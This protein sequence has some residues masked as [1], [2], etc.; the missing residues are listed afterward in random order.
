MTFLQPAGLW[1]LGLIPVILLIHLFRASPRRITVPATFLWH[2]LNKDLSASR[3]H[4]PPRPSWLLLLQ[5][6]AVGAVALALANPRVVAPPPRHLVLLID[7]SASMLASD[8]AP[9]RFDQAIQRGRALLA[10]LGPQDTVSVIRVG[11][12][13]ALVAESIDPGAA[14]ASLGG[15]RAGAGSAAMREA[16]AFG[17]AL[18]NRSP[19]AT[20]EIVVLSDGAFAEPGDL[21]A[22][23]APIRFEPVGQS[24]E[25][26]AVTSV[27]VARQPRP[28]AG[29]AVFAR[30]VNYANR[31][32]RLPVRLLADSVAVDTR[33]VDVA[34]RARAELTFSAPEGTRRLAVS[35]G[36][37]DALAADDL[38]EVS[39]DAGQARSALLVSRLPGVMERALR[40]IPDLRVETV[41]PEAY[42]SQAAEL[43]VLDGFLPERLPGGQLLIVNP[44]SGRDYLRVDG[45]L[46]A[47][48]VSDLDG[49]HQL[50]EA[51]DLGAARLA[52]MTVIQPPAWARSVAE[53]GG[54]PLIL[55]GRESGRAV[56]IFAFD[57]TGSGVDKMLAFPLLVSNA[58]SYLGGGDVS[59]SLVPGR[60]ADLPLAPGVRQV[61]LERPDGT[62]QNLTPRGG[63]VALEGLEQPGRY[64]VR[65]QGA[66]G[67]AR[68]FSINVA[69]ESESDIA[70]RQRAAVA[71]PPPRA[72]RPSTSPLEVWPWLLGLGLVFFSAEWWRFGRR[73]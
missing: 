34:P 14:Q 66:A 17:A 13:P 41:S 45:E 40:A 69:D 62:V 29:I 39:V 33:E 1:L 16:L 24:R 54:R 50:L 36:G 31:P 21:S 38:V 9:S 8:V 72:D 7:G 57:P 37:R 73:G 60:V 68:V 47:V 25:N 67:G 65:E 63:S 6:L 3:R 35:L 12:S 28:G 55:E 32:V 70:P 52:R 30:V 26:Q 15:L 22:L 20:P 64:T 44:P 11:P 59:P 19:D 49:R 71:G 48:Q 46:R 61:R 2:D 27:R 53:A 58:T 51:V 18:A 43:V 42:S 5:L 4:R 10:T 23:E 56:V